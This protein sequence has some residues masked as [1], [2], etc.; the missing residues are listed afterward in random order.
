MI[1]KLVCIAYGLW[2]RIPSYM[3]KNKNE[4]EIVIG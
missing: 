1:K 3:Y 2:I 4:P